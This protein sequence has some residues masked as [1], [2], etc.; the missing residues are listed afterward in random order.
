MTRRGEIISQSNEIGSTSGTYIELT[1]AGIIG[2]FFFV[3]AGLWAFISPIGLITTGKITPIELTLIGTIVASHGWVMC[4]VLGAAFDVLPFIHRFIPY[5]EAS[6]KSV[7]N[8]NLTGMFIIF[9]GVIIGNIEIFYQTLLIGMSAFAFQYIHLWGPIKT[10][11]QNKKSDFSDPVGISGIA[12]S[13]TILLGSLI[14]ILTGIFADDLDSLYLSMWSTISLIWIPLCWA[15]SLS[16]F[17]RRMGWEIVPIN[18]LSSRSMI[19]GITIVLHF[20]C[21][22]ALYL[23]YMENSI[24][25]LLR[26]SV[27]LILGLMINPHRI[28]KR[29]LNGGHY[30][31]LIVVSSLLISIIGITSV[32]LWIVGNSTPR[33]FIYLG[34]GLLMILPIGIGLTTGYI[35]TLHEDHLHRREEHRKNGWPTGIIVIIAV[36]AISGPFL[37]ENLIFENLSLQI[38]TAIIALPFLLALFR[39]TS[40]W[41]EELIPENGSWNR[42]PMFWNEIHEPLDPYEFNSEE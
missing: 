8:L 25:F 12:P 41:K 20:V 24:P 32:I 2:S 27:I 26:G 14:C 13:I 38:R 33:L 10:L 30:N 42:I 5:Q 36:L 23:R 11:I 15:F 4:F 22:I 37:R 39:M 35:S 6:L 19:L 3:A 18:Q 29:V 31:A 17:N 9:L 34:N 21:E 40:W 16:Y 1:Q 7:Q 28:V